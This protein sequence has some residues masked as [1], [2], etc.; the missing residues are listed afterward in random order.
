MTTD[1]VKPGHPGFFIDMPTFSFI[2]PVK[3]RISPRALESLRQL[4]HSYP[5]EILIS[6]GKRPSRQ[7]NLAAQQ[8]QGEILFFLDDDSLVSGEFLMLC[9][10]AF[11]NTS[12]AVVGGPSL[13]PES[14]STL[15][16]VFGYALSSFFGAGGMR[17]RY[18][19]AGTTRCTTEK[20]LILCNMAIR[21]DIFL[22]ANGFDERL[23]PNEENELLDRISLK[24]FKLVHIPSMA[25]KRSQRQT[26]SAF[27]RQMFSY[28]RGRAQ[29]TLIARKPCPLISLIPLMFVIYL[30]LLP[31]VPANLFLSLP[32]FIYIFLDLI[33]A[34]TALIKSRDSGALLLTA[35][36]PIM[37][38][39]NGLGL[40]Y[41]FLKGSVMLEPGDDIRIKVIKSFE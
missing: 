8:A 5:F 37:H 25:V 22:A 6:E 9:A 29:Q 2:I 23:Y 21:R 17:N 1:I 26:L 28:G 31:L 7:R 36:F 27:V 4:A 14:D 34:T 32:L 24:G 33:F 19:A 38:F 35:I 3:P 40:L 20:E 30:V 39:A 16:Q 10:E 11:T 41:G 18:R 15:Q 12:V 13:T